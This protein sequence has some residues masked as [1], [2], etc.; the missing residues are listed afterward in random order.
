MA[1]HVLFSEPALQSLVEFETPEQGLFA[2]AAELDATV[3]GVTLGEHGSAI[4]RRDGSGGTVNR[5]ASPKITAID[6]LNAG[7]VWHGVYA[8]GLVRGWDLGSIVRAASVAAAIKCERFGGKAGS[9]TL[10]ELLRR[11]EDWERT[12]G[13][14]G[15]PGA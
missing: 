4:W 1:D 15:H 6:T 9:P 14:A 3:V 2:V 7:D 12:T 11:L 8:Y 13:G 5:F 10:P